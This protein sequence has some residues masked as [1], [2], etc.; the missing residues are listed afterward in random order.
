M[1]DAVALHLSEYVAVDQIGWRFIGTA[2]WSEYE[3]GEE[4]RQP[5]SH[6]IDDI[7]S[8]ASEDSEAEPAH[9]PAGYQP[10]PPYSAPDTD[11]WLS[12]LRLELQLQ[13]ELQFPWV[14]L[15]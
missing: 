3:G 14:E 11:S 13:S 15:V 9:T 2:R 1:G 10:A 4:T 6:G 12:K 5:E 7:K 8:L